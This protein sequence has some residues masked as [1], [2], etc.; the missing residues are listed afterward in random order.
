MLFVQEYLRSVLSVF[1][2]SQSKVDILVS[3]E[4]EESILVTKSLGSM[5]FQWEL[6]HGREFLAQDT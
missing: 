1:S 2:H 3:M 6:I 4:L 5:S